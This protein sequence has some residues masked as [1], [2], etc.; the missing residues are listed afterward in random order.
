MIPPK[1]KTVE[2]PTRSTTVPTLGG[3]YIN[4]AGNATKNIVLSGDLY[5]PYVGSPDNPV[6]RDNTGLQN[7]IDGLNEFFKLRWMLIRYR[8]YTMTK[9]AR[10]TVPT[11]LMGLSPQIASLYGAISKRMSKKVGALY[12]EI[13]LIFHDYDMDDHWFCR[14]DSMSSSQ[15]DAKFLAI[16]YTVNL[17]CYEPDSVQK[18]MEVN[19]AKRTSNESVNVI[20][21]LLQNVDFNTQFDAI[22]ADIGY[23][24]NF[25]SA[26]VDIQN[27]IDN[28]NTEN[29]LIQAGK[30]TALTNLPVYVSALT[31]AVNLALAEFID[32]FLSA[33]QQ[34]LY[35]TGDLAIDDVLD[36][37]LISFY[38]TLQKVKLFSEELQGTLNTIVKNEEIRFYANADN[39][40]LSEEQFDSGDE[41]KVEN[42]TSFY[43]YTVLD[44]DTARIIA[45]RELKDSEKYI[46]ILQLNNI[47]END[48]IDGTLI[49]TQIKI[50][51]LAGTVT[52][53]DDNLVYDAN[54]DNIETFLYGSDIATTIDDGLAISGT[55]DILSLDGVDNVV[56]NIENR[57]EARKGSLNIFNPNWGSI[58]IDDSNAPLLVKIDRYLTDVTE[59]I[60]SDPRVE[61]VKMELDKLDFVGERISV[62]I[63]IYFVGTDD[64]REVVA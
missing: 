49:G 47:S 40:T 5:F 26:S 25:V 45:L 16:S 34:V 2:E 55:G 7:T 18:S 12:D 43:Y 20:N 51:L 60:Q 23:N 30:S 9:K 35:D 37:D 32:T 54:P 38:N 53:G 1:S 48:F 29:E 41:N 36:I 17:E 39:Y 8:D 4:D 63:K 13:Q 57:L 22:Q 50:P 46:N 62:P 58:S 64:V 24:A 59:Q 15:S 42:D 28:I 56:D 61:S 52:R 33:D 21:T 19:Q 11:T 44:G 10:M 27:L 14:V 6:A 3:N 31:T